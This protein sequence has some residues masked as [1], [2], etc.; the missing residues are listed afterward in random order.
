MSVTS[1][2]YEDNP[3][4]GGHPVPY[5][6]INATKNYLKH[7][8]NFLMLDFLAKNETDFALRRRADHE[9]TICRRKMRYFKQHGNFD[10]A[11]AL[12]GVE[13][14]KLRWAKTS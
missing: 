4:R 6:R 2:I 9:L 7:Y 1:I 3:V 12:K 13:L 5:H 10:L 11:E 8:D 14:L